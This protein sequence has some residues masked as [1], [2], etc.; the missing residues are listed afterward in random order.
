MLFQPLDHKR[1]CTGYYANNVIYSETPMPREGRT[2]DYSPHL[3]SEGQYEIARIYAGGQTLTE[4]CPPE[5]ATQW[6]AIKDHVRAC[7]KSFHTAQLSL[8]QNCFYD[9]V[10][11]YFLYQYLFFCCFGRRLICLKPKSRCYVP[12]RGFVPIPLNSFPSVF[13][14]F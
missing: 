9:V 4:V 1:D 6:Q 13:I 5:L 10:P 12:H 7:L 3:S 14:R 2:W 11:Q 8:Q